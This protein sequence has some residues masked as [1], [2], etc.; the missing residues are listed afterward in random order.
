MV[1][2]QMGMLREVRKDDATFKGF[3][4]NTIYTENVGEF[5]GVCHNYLE[6]AD[7]KNEKSTITKIEHVVFAPSTGTKRRLGVV[8]RFN[9]TFRENYVKF[10]NLMKK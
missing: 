6:N 2:L 5:K 10:A 9:W 1:S 8:K 3:E 4:R 7:P